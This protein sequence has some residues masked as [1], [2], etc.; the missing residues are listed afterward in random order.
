MTL[1]VCGIE[2]YINSVYKKLC[3]RFYYVSCIVCISATNLYA[4]CHFM[5]EY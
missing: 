3:E 2:N 1:C 4:C 5:S